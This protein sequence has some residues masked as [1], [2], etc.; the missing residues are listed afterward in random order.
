[1]RRVSI[2]H[3]SH[4]RYGPTSPGPAPAC[5]PSRESLCPL[6]RLDPAEGQAVA[7]QGDG[8]PRAGSAACGSP[9]SGTGAVAGSLPL[10]GL[11]FPHGRSQRVRMRPNLNGRWRSGAMVPHPTSSAALVDHRFPPRGIGMSIRTSHSWRTRC[12]DLFGF[13]DPHMLLISGTTAVL[14]LAT[15]PF[16]VLVLPCMAFCADQASIEGMVGVSACRTSTTFAA[17]PV[18]LDISRV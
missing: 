3:R 14:A 7:R 10:T 1:L 16:V 8:L 13:V 12:A 15:V 11:T 5:R 18:V 9:G 2:I 6:M 17:I 4:A